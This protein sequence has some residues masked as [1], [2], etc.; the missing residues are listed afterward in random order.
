MKRRA[1]ITLL[2]G[3]AVAWPLAARAQ[4]PGKVPTIGFL[5]GDS[6]S[7]GPWVAAFVAR[8]RELGWI[9]RRTVEIEYRWMEGRPER[10]AEFAAEFVRLKV[11]IIVTNFS[12]ALAVKHATSIIPIVFVLGNDP[13]GS[14]IVTNLARPGG[15]VTGQAL[16]QTSAGKRLQLLVEFVPRLRRLAIIANAGVPDAVHEIGDV[17]ALAPMLGLEVAR[18][19]IRRAEDIAPA[20]EAIRDR[21]DALYVVVDALF[22]T[23]RT[24]ITTLALTARLPIILNNREFVKAGALMSYGPDFLAMFGRAAECVDKILRGAKPGE[25]PVEQPTKFEIVVNVTTAKALGLEIPPKLLALANE[26]IE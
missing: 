6:T 24:L 16:R 15:N 5:G 26:V 18:F 20:F 2:G 9:G 23:N 4:Q 10:A 1:F 7:W 25:I 19:E 22:N 21:A 8:L 13:L 14:G 17:Q 3:A 11:D 12:S